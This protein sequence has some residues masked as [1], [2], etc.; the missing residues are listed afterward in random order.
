MRTL[1]SYSRNLI[2][3]LSTFNRGIGINNDLPWNLRPDLK[4]F[5]KLT[6]GDGNNAVLMGRNTLESLPKG[7]LPERDNLVLSRTMKS[8]NCNVFNEWSEMDDYILNKNYDELWIIGGEGVYND[9]LN[10][11]GYVDNIYLTNVIGDYECDTFFPQLG[12]NYKKTEQTE[13]L[14]YKEY[15]YFYEKYVNMDTL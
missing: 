14:E 7:Y 2:V 8:D 1:R 5:K 12:D 11:N 13:I 15:K 9:S 6:V 10:R 4:R 3:S